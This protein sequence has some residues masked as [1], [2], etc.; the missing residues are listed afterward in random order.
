MGNNANENKYLLASKKYKKC[1]ACGGVKREKDISG[2]LNKCYLCIRKD[3]RDLL[4]G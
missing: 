3:L 4:Y 2:R 1:I